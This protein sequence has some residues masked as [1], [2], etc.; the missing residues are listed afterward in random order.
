M[1]CVSYGSGTENQVSVHQLLHNWKLLFEHCSSM[2]RATECMLGDWS[3]AAQGGE[4]REERILAVLWL[5]HIWFIASLRPCTIAYCC[6]GRKFYCLHNA[7]TAAHSF[8][9]VA[10]CKHTGAPVCTH[11][12][13][14]ALS[15]AQSISFHFIFYLR[16]YVFAI[17]DHSGRRCRGS[18]V[19]VG[20][21][22]PTMN[23][24]MHR[25]A[26]QWRNGVLFTF[27]RF[28]FLFRFTVFRRVQRT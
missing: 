1:R 6:N 3:R 8:P 7:H 18:I 17:D 10:Q 26:L 15:P 11:T 16:N 25:S 19:C 4:K 12:H 24:K 21:C 14:L 23:G 27:L 5:V 2:D 9:A 13:T 28:F 22:V 20:V